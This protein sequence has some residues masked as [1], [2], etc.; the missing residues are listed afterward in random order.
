[1]IATVIYLLFNWLVTIPQWLSLHDYHNFVQ[2]Q[3]DL[4]DLDRSLP[5]I[6]FGISGIAAGLSALGLPET[7]FTPMPQTV[8]EA[9]AWD[10]DYSL[11]CMTKR[12]SGRQNNYEKVALSESPQD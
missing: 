1:M 3:A 9:E 8:E 12:Y 5:L 11:P 10:E 4:L 2:F 7:H 6:I